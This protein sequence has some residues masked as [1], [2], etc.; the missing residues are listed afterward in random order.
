MVTD[1][2]HRFFLVFNLEV[3]L[4]G[5]LVFLYACDKLAEGNPLLFHCC[6]HIENEHRREKTAVG[7]EEIPEIVVSGKLASVDSVQFA[8]LVGCKGTTDL[9]CRHLCSHRGEI[10]SYGL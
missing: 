6:H 8:E 5:I 10:F 3:D 1:S 9:P 7:E 2:V 4:S